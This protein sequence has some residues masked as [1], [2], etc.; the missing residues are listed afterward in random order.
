MILE[1]MRMIKDNLITSFNT[2]DLDK[3][4]TMFEL[5]VYGYLSRYEAGVFVIYHTNRHTVQL[6][7]ILSMVKSKAVFEKK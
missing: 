7:N 5:P 4:C 1:S 6:T 3:T 2:L